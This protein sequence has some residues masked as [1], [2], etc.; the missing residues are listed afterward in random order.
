MSQ[1]GSSPNLSPVDRQFVS[2]GRVLQYLREVEDMDG[3]I[4]AT[5]DYLRTNFEYKLLWIATYDREN[6]RLV[7]RGGVTPAGEI[8]FLKERMALQP[9]DL[10][11][12][13]ILQRKPVPIADLRQEKRSGEWQKV[14]QKFE[15]QG[16]IVFP[17]YHSETSYGLAL[18][19]SHLW[20]V[21]PRTDEKARLAMVFGTLGQTLHRV[22]QHWQ[23]QQTKRPDIT[24]LA[25]LERLRALD[26]LAARLEEV[27][28]RTHQ[29][30]M[31]TRTC[32]YWFEREHRYFWRRTVN[33]K[34]GRHQNDVTAGLT[35]NNAPALYQALAKDQMVVVADINTQPGGILNHRLMEQ[36]EAVALMAA[37]IVFQGELMGFLSIESTE[38]RLWSEDEKNFTRAAAQLVALTAP[39]D[40]MEATVRRVEADRILTTGIAKAV[41]SSEDVI[42]SLQNAAEQLCDRLGAERFWLASYNPDTEQFDTA[43]QFH[44]KNRRPLPKSLSPLSEV[45][46]QMMEQS[47]ETI[48]IETLDGDYKFLS[49]RPVLVDLEVKSLLLCSTSIGKKL[50]GILAIAHE[51]PRSWTRPEREMVKAV[52]QQVGLIVRQGQLQRETDT[53]L[54][55]YQAIQYGLVTLQQVGT[56]EQL[57][58]LGIQTIAQVMEAPMAALVTWLPGRPGGQLAAQY[59]TAEEFK[60]KAAEPILS[61]DQDDLVQ[62]ALQSESFLTLKVEDLTENTRRWLNGPGLGQLLVMALRTSPDHR[63]TGLLVLGDKPER[64]WLDRQLQAFHM[65]VNQLAWSRRHL[66]LVE[67]LQSQR[68]ELERLNWYKHRRIE[69]VYRAVGS[70]VQRLLEVENQIGDGAPSLRVQQSLKQLQASLSPLPQ[71]IRKEQWRLRVNYETAPLAGI[72]KR[73]LERVEG[74]IRQRQMWSQVHNQANVTIGGDIAKFEMVVHEILLFSCGR[75]AVGGRIDI[76]CRQIDEKSLELSITDFGEIEG[77]LLKALH[78]G[79]ELDILA[80]SVLD[81]PP[82]LHLAICQQLMQ[83]AGGELT[84][85]QLED[86]RVLSRLI[87]PIAAA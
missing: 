51:A 5:L 28:E 39:L 52:A 34:G 76:W 9:G 72:L 53:R 12:Q 58:P 50:E 13:V 25:M 74:P 20:N 42:D 59:A 78:E 86:N 48:A 64:R 67:T 80:P 10:M 70:G 29:F 65:L 30:V 47:F 43:F 77:E 36:M 18:L 81:R 66:V 46:W 56:L 32:I 41:F 44:P 4:A 27:V 71:M 68:Q 31:P 73:S 33:R 38:P 61:I 63:P 62:W 7:G 6:H 24:L 8:K 23:Q 82:G 49:W 3:A 15:V 40:E 19:G 1:S 84:L 83:E 45:D 2:L 79:R 26:A 87:L 69:D 57:H 35:V 21:V 85:Y 11:D 16:T 22:E 17:I 37:P 75:S 55:L 14:A 60:L 54:R